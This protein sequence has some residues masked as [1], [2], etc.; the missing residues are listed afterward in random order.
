MEEHDH[1][2][3]TEG[4]VRGSLDLFPVRRCILDVELMYTVILD[5]LNNERDE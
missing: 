2:I 1:E 4:V 3:F 5:R